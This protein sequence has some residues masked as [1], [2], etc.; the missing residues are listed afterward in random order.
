MKQI[1]LAAMVISTLLLSGCNQQLPT[2]NQNSS[3]VIEDLN[4]NQQII[5]QDSN[6]NQNPLKKEQNISWLNDLVAQ[7]EN[8]PVA[9]PPASISK[10]TYKG[11]SVYYLPPRCCDIFS[12]L[13]NE[14]GEI[15][16][17]PDGG[18]TGMGDGKCKDFYTEKK[19]CEIIWQD[20]R[21]YP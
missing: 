12:E 9:N 21:S 4:L 10:C 7:K 14:Q 15:I 20:S 3:Q 1:F 16:C 2:Q 19:D 17:A 13:R 8:E 6:V 11:K 18:F 5:D